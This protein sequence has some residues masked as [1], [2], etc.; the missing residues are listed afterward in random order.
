[1]VVATYEVELEIGCDP[2]PDSR[3]IPSAL[4]LA[5]GSGLETC[6]VQR[7]LRGAESQL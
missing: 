2:S 6:D 7:D 1:M 3:T 5:E 4:W